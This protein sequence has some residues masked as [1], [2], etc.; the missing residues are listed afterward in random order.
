MSPRTGV[1]VLCVDDHPDVAHTLVMLFNLSGFEARE[2]LDGPSAVAVA[3]EF[4][5][6]ACVVDVNMPVMDGYEVARRLREEFGPTVLLIALSAMNGE[7]HERRVVAAGFD[8]S[9]TKPPSLTR[10]LEAVASAEGRQKNA[11]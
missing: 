6:H 3:R 8:L 9:F 5:P 10:L 1:R 11:S 7:E 4:R 2:C